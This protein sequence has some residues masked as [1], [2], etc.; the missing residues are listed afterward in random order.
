MEHIHHI[1]EFK[2]G[3]RI[4][5]NK[6]IKVSVK[7]HAEYHKNYFKK[8]GHYQDKIA[9]LGLIKRLPKEKLVRE[10]SRMANLGRKQ[11]PEQIEKRVNQLR[12]K[13]RIFTKQW[14][15][16]ISKS[17]KGKNLKNTHTKGYK[18]CHNGKT[19]KYCKIIP[20]G[21]VQGRL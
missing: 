5:T 1:I 20:E 9:W 12:G 15:E 19:T 18:W 4:R 7:Q 6:T 13:K 11:T 3:Q 21:F 8:Y 2:D 10:L 14:I 17:M 16:N